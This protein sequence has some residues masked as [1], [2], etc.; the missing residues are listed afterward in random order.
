M[1]N[2][3]MS[4]GTN[5]EQSKKAEETNVS[6]AIGNTDVVCIQSPTTPNR[7]H[8]Y[9]NLID[10]IKLL[11][12]SFGDDLKG[13]LL[14]VKEEYNMIVDVGLSDKTE[15]G[16]GVTLNLSEMKKYLD[17]KSKSNSLA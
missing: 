5:A 10:E 7:E 2:E 11:L 3:E 9:K 17:Y 4:A 13:F 16:F 1:L 12:V 6:P 15:T 14:H 8:E